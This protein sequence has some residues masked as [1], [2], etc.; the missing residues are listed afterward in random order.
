MCF[1]FVVQRQRGTWTLV[2]SDDQRT[3]YTGNNVVKSKFVGVDYT[4]YPTNS[5]LDGVLE[6]LE[7]YTSKIV[8]HMQD[9]R[10]DLWNIS[11]K[12]SAAESKRL[13]ALEKIAIAERLV[14][15]I[16]KK[17]LKEQNR[18]RRLNE[19]NTSAE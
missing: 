19:S 11:R 7:P 10:V 5:S 13:R 18:K 6:I 8:Q 14:A 15:R 1:Y 3:D 9:E 2:V 12:K 16:E 4:A 17:R